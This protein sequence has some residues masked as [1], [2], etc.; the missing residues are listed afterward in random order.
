MG[1]QPFD[2]ILLVSEKG[3]V[4]YQNKNAGPQFTTLTSLLQAQPSP[5]NKETG[6]LPATAKDDPQD[7]ITRNA[8]P[9][10]R[11]MSKNLT[12]VVLAG[13]RYKLFLQP[14][15]IDVYSDDPN[16][17]EPAVEW[18][19]C[20]LKSAAGLQWESLSISY[21]FIIWITALFFAISM[22]GPILKIILLNHRER[23]RLREVG[24]LGLFL[25][26]LTSVFTL[27]GL[28]AVEFPLNDDTEARLQQ[29]G[30]N[31]SASVWKELGDMRAQLKNWCGLVE[32]DLKAAKETEVIRNAPTSGAV[33]FIPGT[34]KRTPGAPLYPYLNNAFWTDDDGHQV[35][36]WSLSSY[37][38]PMIDISALPI[39]TNPKTTYLDG[40]PPAFYF[41]SILPPNKLE[42]LATIT[43]TTEDCDPHLSAATPGDIRGD[44][45]AGAAFL[46]AQ[47]LSLIDPVLPLG[48]GF[49]LVDQNG[50]V[51][52]HSD[53]TKNKRENFRQESDWSRQLYAATFGHAAP[54]SLPIKY[55]GTDYRALVIPIPGVSQSP[56]SLIVY[57][58]LTPVRTI[59][60]QVMTMATTLLLWL[61][62]VPVVIM[63][64]WGIIR[65]PLFAPEWLWP[66]RARMGAYLYLI[67]VYAL[68]IVSFLFLGFGGSGERTVM[69]CATIPYTA[70]LLTWWCFRLYPSSAEQSIAGNA[71]R[72]LAAPA[73]VSILGAILFLALLVFQ[74][75]YLKPLTFLLFVVIA[76][77]VPLLNGPR[78]FL[79]GWLNHRYPPHPVEDESSVQSPR[80][81]FGYRN[82]Y[83]LG[84]LLLLLLIGVLTP[85]ALF[86][87]SLSVERRLGLKQAQ[88]HLASALGSR[89]LQASEQCDRGDLG[90]AACNEFQKPDSSAWRK[91][92]FDPLFPANGSLPVVPH[93]IPALRNFTAAGFKNSFIPF[94]MTTIKPP[95]KCWE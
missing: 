13:T 31:L 10:W 94:T 30:D 89:L 33:S 74:W 58:D 70:L 56:W 80:S 90:E 51:L 62:A 14:I 57:R 35:V 82:S 52:F 92:V 83:M 95:P 54:H 77:A 32:E 24:F 22:S 45:K 60:L 8:D 34:I 81:V 88:L 40:K 38:T 23:L 73:T 53:K 49:A 42:Y 27:S 69:A 41:D 12:D 87:A 72:S 78:R 25:V 18:V 29:L 36:K 17:H 86:Q 85:M 20:G 37:L 44:I 2:E 7:P 43:M 15:L 11:N 59:N 50:L 9:T 21:I 84:V 79:I 55:L 75:T 16:H 93:S 1:S 47:P 28:Q 5:A 3:T 6:A 67:Y 46:T 48:Y 61:L 64:V 76:C 68:L 19:L 71:G 91:L 65:R 39:F 26:L 4:V 63:A 66:N